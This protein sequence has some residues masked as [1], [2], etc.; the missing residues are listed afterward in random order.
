MNQVGKHLRKVTG[1][2]L[3][4]LMLSAC[5]E[6]MDD[7]E[8]YIVAVKAK[9]AKPIEPVPSVVSYPSYEYSSSNRDPFSKFM[10][11]AE[12][13]ESPTKSTGPQ[14]DF[15]RSKEYLASGA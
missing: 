9:P 2:V 5:T 4:T 15:G 13:V 1:A 14:P 3:V 12:E 7:L 6:S 10:D 11:D 8:K